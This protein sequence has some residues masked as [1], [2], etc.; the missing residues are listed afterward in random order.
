MD[1]FGHEELAFCPRPGIYISLVKRKLHV[2]PYVTGKKHDQRELE[3]SATRLKLI[4][5]QP[6]FYKNFT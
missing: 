6:T 2:L 1:A 4:S 3:I 5:S